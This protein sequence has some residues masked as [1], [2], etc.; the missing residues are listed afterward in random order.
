MSIRALTQDDLD[1]FAV[2][3]SDVKGLL[4]GGSLRDRLAEGRKLWAID[5]HTGFIKYVTKV[6][7]L[8]GTPGQ[9][10]NVLYAGRCLFYTRCTFF[11]HPPCLIDMPM[12]VCTLMA[13]AII[14]SPVLGYLGFRL[15]V[16][17]GQ[18]ISNACERFN[19]APY[20]ALIPQASRPLTLV[21]QTMRCTQE[22][23]SYIT[24]RH[25]VH[26]H[27]LRH[28][29]RK[30]ICYAI[31]ADI[32]EFCRADGVTVPVSIELETDGQ[33]MRVYTPNSPP[34]ACFRSV[35]FLR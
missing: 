6:A 32:G 33:P 5:F 8:P 11:L 18:W 10:K 27:A 22:K 4:E 26:Q 21:Q 16:N 13:L 23:K 17:D 7:E 1:T 29:S 19:V 34:E 14:L 24:D 3:E 30:G 15:D 20:V 25:P 28:G 2:R 31:R 35:L 12:F 9:K